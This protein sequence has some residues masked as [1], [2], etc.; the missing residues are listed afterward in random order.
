MLKVN[1]L[2]L[3]FLLV[4]FLNLILHKFCSVLTRDILGIGTIFIEDNNM[5][6]CE[7]KKSHKIPLTMNHA[8][9]FTTLYF[10]IVQV[11]QQDTTR[12]HTLKVF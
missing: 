10:S 12:E 11:K 9:W 4:F 7:D 3:N 1:I 5:F 6:K 8:H 2:F